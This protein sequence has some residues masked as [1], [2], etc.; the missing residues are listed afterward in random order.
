MSAQSVRDVNHMVQNKRG[1]KYSR[2]LWTLHKIGPCFVLNGDFYCDCGLVIAHHHR[3]GRKQENRQPPRI[4]SRENKIAED[5]LVAIDNSIE[6]AAELG[7]FAQSP[8]YRSVQ[9]VGG[10]G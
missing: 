9:T 7:G 10:K 2:A 8:C 3:S 5:F 6:I 4:D 1:A